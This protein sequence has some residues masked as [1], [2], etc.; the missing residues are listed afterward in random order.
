VIALL[1]GVLL[2]VSYELVAVMLVHRW[3]YAKTMPLVPVLHVGVVPVLQMMII[4]T[5][6]LLLS[7][8]S[9]R[10]N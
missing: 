6:A 9:L 2:A 5:L 10:N 8:F 1:T 3:Q 7:K 4:P